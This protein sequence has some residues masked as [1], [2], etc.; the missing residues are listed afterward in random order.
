MKFL[1]IVGFIGLVFGVFLFIGWFTFVPSEKEE[2]YQLITA[3]GEKGEAPGQFDDPTGIA[4]TESEVFVADARNN[5]IQVFDFEGNFKRQFG[6]EGEGVGQ[7]LRPMGIAIH[8]DKLYVSEFWNNR[9]QVFK[10]DGTPLKVVVLNDI[11]LNFPGGV[12]VTPMG[13]LVV[14]DTY[15]H[16]IVEINLEGKL[17]RQWGITEKTGIGSGEFNYPMDV[18]VDTEGCIYVADGYNDRI[19]VLDSSGDFLRKWGGPFGIDIPGPFNGWFKVTSGIALDKEGNVYAIDFY[20]NRVQKFS[21]QGVFLTKFGNEPPRSKQLNHPLKVAVTDNG[22]V[23]VTDHLNNRV[24]KW[25]QKDV[26]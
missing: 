15:N 2:S 10:L 13:T 26:E 22:I 6:S 24:T 9:I 8:G 1:K 12:A 5:R 11:P 17:I 23:F 20:N 14:A 16:R 4:V 21:N 3:W 19:Q 7:L 18:A 25:K